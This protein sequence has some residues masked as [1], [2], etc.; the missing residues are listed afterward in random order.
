MAGYPYIV[1]VRTVWE[2][3]RVVAGLADIP[4]PE[5]RLISWEGRVLE[6]GEIPPNSMQLIQV[7]WDEATLDSL[8]GANPTLPGRRDLGR[9][10]VGRRSAANVAVRSRRTRPRP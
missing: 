1:E 10:R 7:P 3:L 4:P 8:K 6:W 5:I 9:G 2:A